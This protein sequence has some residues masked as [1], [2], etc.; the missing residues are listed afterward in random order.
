MSISIAPN[1]SVLP[2]DNS[3]IKEPIIAVCNP[4]NPSNS[5]KNDNLDLFVE[6]K[7]NSIVRDKV[8]ITSARSQSAGK[9]LRKSHQ[10]SM[11]KPRVEPRMNN[12][13]QPQGGISV[14]PQSMHS[15]EVRSAATHSRKR[16]SNNL[17][18][19]QREKEDVQRAR[20]Q[21]E[22]YYSTQLNE[23]DVFTLEN[24]QQRTLRSQVPQKPRLTRGQIETTKSNDRVTNPLEFLD[25]DIR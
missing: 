16:S 1:H 17:P 3:H 2:N 5:T 11:T 24:I 7:K 10:S 19:R 25:E 15:E 20:E 23:T 8:R 21:S 18:P 13:T 9:Q 14:N 12:Y 6:P 4:P 22:L